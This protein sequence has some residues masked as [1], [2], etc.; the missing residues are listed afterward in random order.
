MW[1]DPKTCHDR[2]ATSSEDAVDIELRSG[3]GVAGG[4]SGAACTD[5]ALFPRTVARAFRSHRSEEVA[6]AHGERRTKA[7]HVRDTFPLLNLS[8]DFQPVRQLTPSLP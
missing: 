2:V 1:S 8:H 4:K 5:R 3:D 7:D 6:T